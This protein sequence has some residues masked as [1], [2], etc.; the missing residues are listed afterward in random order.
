[1][2]ESATRAEGGAPSARASIV[3]MV[4]DAGAI[5]VIRMKDAAKVSALVET[6]AAGGVRILEITMTVPGAIEVIRSISRDLP[7]G[8]VLGAGTVLDGDTAR[9]VIEAG[10]RFVDHGRQL[11][12]SVGRGPARVHRYRRTD[13]HRQR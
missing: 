10:A 6:L 5:A 13:L 2:T 4:E 1:M 11:R 9:R 12:F 3:G 8:V 7:A